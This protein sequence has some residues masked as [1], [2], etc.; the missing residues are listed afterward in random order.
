M[1]EIE[2]LVQVLEKID[3]A[4]KKLNDSLKYIGDKDIIDFYFYNPLKYKIDPSDEHPLKEIIRVRKA[5]NKSFITYKKNKFD[6]KG[7]WLYSD[8]EEVEVSNSQSAIKIIKKLGFKA[9]IE[10]KNTKSVFVNDKYEVVLEKVKDLGYFLEVEIRNPTKDINVESA[11]NGIRQF[12][13][14]LNI[15][16]GK[17]LNIGKPELMLKKKLI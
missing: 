3:T 16:V 6:E 5:N 13:K 9:L 12:I 15:K 4:K 14:D 1:K 11:K 2:I 10:V 7:N 17:E 8:E